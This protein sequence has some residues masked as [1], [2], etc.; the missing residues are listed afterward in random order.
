VSSESTP[1]HVG[2][3]FSS[4]SAGVVHTCGLTSGGAYCWGDNYN[5]RLGAGTGIFAADS[6]PT[7]VS[8]GLILGA[9]AVGANQSCGVT[10]DHV[11]YCWGAN[12]SGELGTSTTTPSPTPMPVRGNLSFMS[13]SA[14]WSDTCGVT[15]QNAVYCW[16][17]RMAT[18]DTTRI[19]APVLVAGAGG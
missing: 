7:L 13:I 6:V 12:D 8:G 3:T 9:I 1:F 19:T 18:G 16:G 14:G 10:T 11:A 4:I 2:L 15:T 5:G 17:A